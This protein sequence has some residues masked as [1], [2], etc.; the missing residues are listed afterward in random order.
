MPK[1]PARAHFVTRIRFVA[2]AIVFVACVIL[3]RLYMLQVVH[4]AEYRALAEDQYV[5]E[6][7]NQIERGSIFMTK[8]DGSLISA[9][10]IA[11]G[12]T[13]AVNPLQIED[14]AAAYASVEPLLPDIDKKTF[15]AKATKKND[16][17]EEI[18]KQVADETGK[19][20][21]KLKIPG[22]EVLR[23]RWRFYPGG[24]LAAHVVGFL[25]YGPDGKTVT[26]Q[27]GLERY[28]NE[29]LLRG[30]G[31][32]SVNFFAELF[33]DISQQFFSKSA[34]P[35]ADVVTSIE[36]S[37][38]QFIERMLDKYD[39]T[40]H[41]KTSGAIIMDP[42]TGAIVA[43]AARPAFDPNDFSQSSNADFV[44]PMVERVYEFGSI[45]KPLTMA[46]GIDAGAV[47]PETTYNDK[48]SAT[49]DQSKIS[50]FDGKA[51]GVVSMQEVLSQSL[52]TG[53]AFVVTRMGT[54][55]FRDYFEK[56]GITDETGVDL[57]SEASALAD[58]FKSPRTIEYVTASFGQGIALTPVAMTR[59]LATLANGGNVPAP[60]VGV[61]L[62]YGGGITKTLGWSPE[63]RA[64]SEESAEKVTKMLV[65]VVDTALKH[66]QAKIPE[67][68][69]AAK[70]GTAQIANPNGG[71]YYSDRYLHSFFGYF[72][73]YN[74]KFIVFFFALEPK[75]AQYASET[76]TDPF[77]ETVHF[78]IN[79][80]DIPPDRASL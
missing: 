47:T 52:N 55:A 1:P 19:A 16:S 45:M 69:I 80:Y 17:Y 49:F 15:I 54:G 28:Y 53:V 43:M 8:K 12:Y 11:S 40:W 41:P 58:N 33:T 48:G 72:P 36:P 20:I 30:E 73:A 24:T 27:Y 32:I 5:R 68:S 46:A 77:I 37:T 26:G 56:Y 25:G 63:R 29:A 10:T 6:S 4:G 39:S 61:E 70:T 71:G 34:V 13:I 3:V 59:A 38:Q 44:N 60:H 57:P 31:G 7:P 74:P 78:L 14:A 65:K 35:G 75:G 79:Y 21:S 9:A 22:V 18:T 67:Y 23:E 62:R 76:W 66:G 64:I 50:N 42:K 51:R 2:I